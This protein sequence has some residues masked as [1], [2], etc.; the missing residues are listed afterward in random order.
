MAHGY[1]LASFLSPLTNRRDDEY[2]GAL[3]NRL[4]FPLEVFDA[5]RAVWPAAKPISVRI[6]ATDWAHGGLEPAEDAWSVARAA[7]RR[8][9]ATS[10]TSRPGRRCPSSE[11]VYGRLF[12]TPFAI[13]SATRRACPR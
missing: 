11:P 4:R 10:S 3:E 1:L 7:P 13:A 12:Q 5:V 9:A 8:T 6:S 2:G